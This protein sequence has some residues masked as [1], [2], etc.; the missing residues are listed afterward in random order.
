MDVQN[1]TEPPSG[2]RDAI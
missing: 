1:S 2:H